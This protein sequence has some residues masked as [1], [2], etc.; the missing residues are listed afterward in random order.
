VIARFNAIAQPANTYIPTLASADAS[1]KQTL[2]WRTEEGGKIVELKSEPMGDL[3][4][5]VKTDLLTL[6]P[7][8]DL[9]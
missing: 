8:D 2:I 1:G 7:L 9:L 3:M 4:K 5:G 6:L